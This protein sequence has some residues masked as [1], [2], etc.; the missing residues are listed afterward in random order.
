M[1]KTRRLDS[2][3]QSRMLRIT[4]VRTVD[5]KFL[6]TLNVAQIFLAILDGTLVVLR[7]GTGTHIFAEI[8]SGTS[9]TAQ[10]LFE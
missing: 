4:I 3:E 8:G 1:Q 9:V 5:Y 7:A 10:V 2:D 6:L